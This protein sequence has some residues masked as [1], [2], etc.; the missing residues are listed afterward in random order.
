MIPSHTVFAPV[1]GFQSVQAA[2]QRLAEEKGVQICLN[3]TVTSVEANGVRVQGSDG[4]DGDSFLPAEL[5]IVNADL[6]YSTQTILSE[7]TSCVSA[8]YDWDDTFDFSSGV[9]AFHWSVDKTLPDLNTHNVFL[10]ANSRSESEASWRVLRA[11][12]VST[13][14][15]VDVEPFN[16]YVHRAGN[17]DLSAAPKG[18]D[19]ILVLVP[20]KTLE[21]NKD[22][23]QLPRK[24]AIEKYK[25]Q[26]DDSVISAAREA[27]L[28]RLAVID[29]LQNLQDHII[30]EVVDTPG[31]YADLYNVG[32]GTPFALVRTWSLV[33]RKEVCHLPQQ[34]LLAFIPTYFVKQSHS[35]RQLSVTRPGA[36]SSNMPNVLFVGA[37]SRPGNGVPLVLL[38]AKQVAQKALNKLKQ[39]AKLQ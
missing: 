37:S 11:S 8:G 18:C 28:E 14:T 10:V 30:N 32:A 3:T 2:F 31:T 16:F 15:S 21:R 33:C 6:P 38:S 27:V 20:C 39:L 34:P 17:T 13:T 12:S 19:A 7:D 9:I 25:Q 5:V 23:A 35:F 26:F 36:E 22:F 1:G 24:E 4:N 29:S